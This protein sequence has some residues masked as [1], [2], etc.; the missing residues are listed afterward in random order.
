[1]GRGGGAPTSRTT[2][3]SRRA[4]S[5]TAG[6]RAREASRSKVKT[7]RAPRR[8]HARRSCVPDS[9]WRG[10]RG[11]QAVPE[12]PRAA[13][14]R[15]GACRGG[16]TSGAIACARENCR[17]SWPSG[18]APWRLRPPPRPGRLFLAKMGRRRAGTTRRRTGRDT[19]TRWPLLTPPCKSDVWAS[20]LDFPLRAPH[21]SVG[22]RRG[23]ALD[24]WW[25]RPSR[26][27][28]RRPQVRGET[29]RRLSRAM[30]GIADPCDASTPTDSRGRAS[31]RRRRVFSY[32][33]LHSYIGRGSRGPA[34][35]R[36][37]GA[38]PSTPTRP[39]LAV[40]DVDATAVVPIH[41]HCPP[42]GSVSRG[43]PAPRA[44]IDAKSATGSPSSSTFRPAAGQRIVGN[45]VPSNERSFLSAS[46][47][48][49]IHRTN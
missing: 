4:A 3:R 2:H 6:Q 10:G 8:E 16:R 29:W 11:C 13:G 26:R 47:S 40:D 25:R 21:R 9:E 18:A 27:P 37:F 24:P 38:L 31:W 32:G 42:L 48:G 41:C 35:A 22:C 46:R 1:M 5:G 43:C 39:S 15:S 30:H 34:A 33:A 20:R 36:P 7:A 12:R 45:W 19:P 28:S 14:G 17:V 49:Y 44:S 23:I